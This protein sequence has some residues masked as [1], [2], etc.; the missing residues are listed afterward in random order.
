MTAPGLGAQWQRLC[1]Q[2]KDLYPWVCHLCRQPIPRDAPPR[3][4]LSWSL[5]HL[6]ARSTHGTQVPALDRVRP[7]HLACNGRRGKRPVRSA[8]RSRNW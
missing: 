8:P 7:A 6:D 3:S 4:R 1:E 2:A 5:D